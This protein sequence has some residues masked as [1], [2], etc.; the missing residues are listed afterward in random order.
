MP[1]AAQGDPSPDLIRKKSD[2]SVRRQCEL[3]GVT[4]SRIYHTP[5]LP[6]EEAVERKERVMALIPASFSR[7]S[8]DSINPC[9]DIP[10][11]IT[12]EID[13]SWSIKGGD[14]HGEVFVKHWIL[15]SGQQPYL[16]LQSSVD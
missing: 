12:A 16:V 1:F 9:V 6:N 7:V 10:I 2:L 13:D 8:S 11:D 4:R 14:P 5:K 15:K 3:L